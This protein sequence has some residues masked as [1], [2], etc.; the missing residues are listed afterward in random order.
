MSDDTKDRDLDLV[1]KHA[2]ELSEYFD[3]V[4]IFVTRHDGT[5]GTV[6]LTKGRGNFYAQYGH[7][8]EW[9][10]Q[11]DTETDRV[12]RKNCEDNP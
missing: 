9:L 6:H 4:R 3:S 2:T 1:E 5:K 11:M 7:V 12:A 8:R 10:I